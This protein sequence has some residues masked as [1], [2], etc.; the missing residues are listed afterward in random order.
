MPRKKTPSAL[1]GAQLPLPTVLENS[2]AAVN[3]AAKQIENGLTEAIFGAQQTYNTSQLS[4]T[5]T[6]FKNNRW[7]LISNNRQLVSQIYVEHGLVKTIVDVPVDDALRGGFNVKSKQLDPEQILE[8]LRYVDRNDLNN[9][10][11]GQ[12]MKWNRLYGGAGQLIITDQNPMLPFDINLIN[13]KSNLDWRAVDM[14][15]L[16][17]AMQNTDEYNPPTQSTE[18][19][20]FN[21]YGTKLHR[22]RV[23]VLKGNEAPSFIRP[24]LRNWGLSVLETLVRSINQYLKSNDLVFEV[25]DEF[26][27]DIFKIKNLT[28]TLLSA[29]GTDAVRKRVELANFQKNYMNSMTMDAEDDFIQKALSFAGVADMMKEFRVQIA[30]DMRM[31]MTKLF[32]LSATGFN[33]GEDDIENYNAMIESE[34]RSKCKY[35][36]VTVLEIICKHL[37]DFVPSDLDIEFKS[38]RVLTS[39]QEENVKEKKFNRVMQAY[40]KGLCS[41]REAQD[42]INKDGLLPVQV[43]VVLDQE[44]AEDETTE[45]GEDDGEESEG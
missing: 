15:E 19:E 14:W 12:S 25:L 7:Y 29:N 10:L 41:G 44:I 11:F 40:D 34:I 20:F 28:Q 32:G 8:L 27:L 4:Q 18:Y 30:S 22:S 37:F 21:Y 6:L 3:Q 36:I 45:E 9:K 1:K 35:H 16:F 31:P 38:L 2:K 42:S 43:E 24:R 23:L 13:K 26:K 17:Y 33:S 39:E 5:T